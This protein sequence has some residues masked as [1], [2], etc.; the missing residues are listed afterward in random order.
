MGGSYGAGNFAMCGKA[1][2][3]RFIFAW[4]T[5]N[6]GVMAGAH[7]AQTLADSRIRKLEREGKKLSAAEKEKLIGSIKK[8]YDAQ[9]DVRYAASRLWV[10]KII[11]PHETRD[12]IALAI[13]LANLNPDVPRFN[14]GVVQV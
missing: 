8:T 5:A 12:A 11:E 1:Y 4:P 7:A 14:V 6:Y 9:L 13:E 2:D 3:P 10:D